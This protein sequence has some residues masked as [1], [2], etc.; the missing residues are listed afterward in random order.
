M[1]A[2]LL[3]AL[4]MGS[5]LIGCWRGPFENLVQIIGGQL[6]SPEH[7]VRYM[8]ALAED[9]LSDLRPRIDATNQRAAG[10]AAQCAGTLGA[11]AAPLAGSIRGL[12]ESEDL[13]TRVRASTALIK[14]S[15][16]TA[17]ELLPVLAAAW[18]ENAHTRTLIAE[19]IGSLGAQAADFLPLMHAE[20]ADPRR[21]TCRQG[22]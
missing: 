14:I 11:E 8:A 21:Y 2:G 6:G 9:F 13:W 3:D 15:C 5:Q 22:F 7:P 1:F 20:L 16:N 12:A 10:L 18:R 19:C 4:R 17:D